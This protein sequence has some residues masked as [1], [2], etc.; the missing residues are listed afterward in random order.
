MKRLSFLLMLGMYL[1]A[2]SP[3]AW[4]QNAGFDLFQTGSG[5]SVDLS[6]LGI[7]VVNLQG[8][9]IQTATGNTDTIIQRTQNGPGTVNAQV[10]ALFMK[11]AGPV[12]FNGQ[13]ADV[14]VT[15]NNS[16]GTI[17]TSTLPQP[18]TLTVSTGTI[19]IGSGGAFSSNITVNADLIIVP[20]GASVTNPANYLAH[21]AAN[22][23]S[24]TSS[25]SSWSTTPPSGYPSSSKFPSGG[26]YVTNINGGHNVPNHPHGIVPASCRTIVVAQDSQENRKSTTAKQKLIRECDQF[27][28]C[29][30]AAQ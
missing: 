4:T 7:G 17:P 14:Y 25:N 27:P 2:V 15:I 9:P 29:I 6:S 8:V 22:S 3:V 18:D 21:Q 19:T 23:V 11:S 12:T 28:C 5:T 26:F 13:S 1:M 10:Y 24:L 16:S 30:E 20:A